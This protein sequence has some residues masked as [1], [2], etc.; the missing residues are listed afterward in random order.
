MF[1]QVLCHRVTLLLRFLDVKVGELRG[2]MAQLRR[3]DALENFKTGKIGVL[4]CTDV[5]ARGL[6]IPHVKTVSICL[7]NNTYIIIMKLKF[8]VH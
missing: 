4:V 3:I 2:N 8:I 5:A 1:V 7:P 6:D